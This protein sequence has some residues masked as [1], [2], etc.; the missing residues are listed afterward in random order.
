MSVCGPLV[1][2]MGDRPDATYGL[3]RGSEIYDHAEQG[4]VNGM[5]SALGRQMDNGAP[6]G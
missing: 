5:I 2:D 1:A 6:L 4:G 3:S